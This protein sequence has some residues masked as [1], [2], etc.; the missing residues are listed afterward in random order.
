ML[1]RFCPHVAPREIR[2]SI[3]WTKGR[4]HLPR[5]GGKVGNIK[6]S[7]YSNSQEHF[8]GQYSYGGRHYNYGGHAIL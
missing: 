1:V 4:Y 8:W 7:I 2:N 5:T 6:D 3:L